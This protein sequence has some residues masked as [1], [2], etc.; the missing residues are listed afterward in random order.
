LQIPYK[1]KKII[2]Y[3]KEKS[4]IFF[5]QTDVSGKFNRQFKQ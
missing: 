1:F 5:S 2:L 4:E 3:L